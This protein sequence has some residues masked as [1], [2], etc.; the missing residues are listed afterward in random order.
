MKTWL[1]IVCVISVV[2]LC[3]FFA[4]YFDTVKVEYEKE[5]EVYANEYNIEKELLMAVA[6]TESGFDKNAKSKVG[7]IGVMQLMPATASFV[8]ESLGEEYSEEKLYDAK[9]N[10]RYGSYY[11]SYLINKYEDVLYALACYNAGEGNVLSWGEP[12]ELDLD[13]IKFSE[14]KNFVKKVMSAYSVY[15]TQ[16]SH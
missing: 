12:G 1:W 14:T 5:F 13:D 15:K 7:A 16:K 6:K 11:L 3:L 8:A 4:V 2:G 10:I 9:T